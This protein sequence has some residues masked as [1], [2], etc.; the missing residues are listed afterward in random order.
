MINIVYTVHAYRWGNRENHSYL[1]GVYSKKEKA[2]KAAYIEEDF[3]GG[4]YKCEVLEWII[5][6]GKEGNHETSPKTILDIDR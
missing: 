4:K 6:K 1:V 5:N 3:R 2:L